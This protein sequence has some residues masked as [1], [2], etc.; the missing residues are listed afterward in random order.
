MALTGKTV[1]DTYKDL[2]TVNSTGSDNQG[3]E[4]SLKNVIDGEGITSAI[5]LSTTHLKIPTG[6]TLEIA[7]T[8]AVS[9]ASLVGSLKVG[10]DLDVTD[11]ISG[12]SMVLTGSMTSDSATIGGGYGS[13][14]TTITSAGNI[15]TNGLLA[16]D[17]TS[18]LAGEVQIGGGH[19]STGVTI[20][21][22]GNISMDGN[23]SCNQLK[24]TSGSIL[25]G[26]GTPPKVKLDDDTKVKLTVTKSGADAEILTVEK[27]GTATFKDEDGDTKFTVK[28][29]GRL[30]LKTLTTSQR[31][32][33]SSPVVGEI[34][35]DDSGNLFAYI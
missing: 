18:T 4:S 27:T 14:G 26:S 35:A 34:V 2:L 20:T 8:L 7:G 23:L 21:T 6:K 24:T 15:Q 9:D 1:A 19:G 25:S 30:K 31:N 10:D 22:T 33:L 13:T 16:V 3:L 5:Q 32:A 12:A 17:G 11:L 29:D 28:D